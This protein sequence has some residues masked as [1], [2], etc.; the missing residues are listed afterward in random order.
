MSISYWAISKCLAFASLI[1]TCAT[2]RAQPSASASAIWQVSL[3]GGSSWQG[4]V[5][6]TQPSQGSVLVRVRISWVL[7]GPTDSPV[8]MN[9]ARF[10]AFSRSLDA[11]GL[12]DLASNTRIL[13]QGVNSVG[14]RDYPFLSIQRQGSI[15]KIDSGA[16]DTAPPGQGPR[17]VQPGQMLQGLPGF[18][19]L[20]E[21]PID[22]FEYRLALDGTEGRRELSG[23]FATGGMG[24]RLLTALPNPNVW[25]N[26]ASFEQ[27]PVVLVVPTPAGAGVLIGA[28]AMLRRRRL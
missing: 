21:N 11:G 27:S 19:L 3:D 4:G 17:W 24:L 8:Y 13:S 22:V 12:G 16:E 18:P 15:L 20:F 14:L 1:L 10:D 6:N 5:V 25:I 2:A 23:V 9:N 26:V 7:D 28:L